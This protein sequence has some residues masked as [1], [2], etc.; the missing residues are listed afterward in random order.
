MNENDNVTSKVNNNIILNDSSN[1]TSY[2][3]DSYNNIVINNTL[4]TLFS[5]F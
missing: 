3:L 4:Y 2:K 5:D 1:A